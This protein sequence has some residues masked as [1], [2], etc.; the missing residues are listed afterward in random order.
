MRLSHALTPRLLPAIFLPALLAAVP[1]LDRPPVDGETD[2]APA[3]HAVTSV[4]P[5]PF[6]W[7]P[8]EGVERY[9][10][11]LS[12][13]PDF[14]VAETVTVRDLDLTVHVPGAV[15]EPGPWYWRYGY[16]RNGA[17]HFGK[18][19]PFRIA[20]DAV[21]LPFPQVSA[22]LARIPGARPRLHFTPEVL[23][24]IRAN[25]RGRHRRTVRDAVRAAEAAIARNEP[26]FEEPRS[27]DDFPDLRSQ[28][29]E[30]FIAMRPY[31]EG[32][33]QCALAY[34]L[35]GE[36]RFAEEARRRLMHFMTWDVDGTSSVIW[37][38]ELGMDIAERAPRTFDWIYDILTE[39]E[40]RLCIDVL[41]RRMAQIHA[42]HRE[43][44]FESRPYSSHPGRMIGFIIEG[45]LA[46]AHEVPEAADWLAYTL[47]LL[48]SVYP[49]WGGEEGGWHEGIGYWNGYMGRITNVLI[50]LDRLGIPIKEKPFFRNTGWFGFYVAYPGR[51]Q[52]GF[53]D[54]YERRVTGGFGNNLY[55]FSTLY[56]NPYFR[57]SAN[58]IGG[59]A[60]GPVAATILDDTL[61]EKSPADLPHSRYFP[62]VGWVAMHSDLANPDDNVMVLFKSAV[63]GSI[64]HD[65]A[66]QNAFTIDAFGE[67]LAISSGF[68]QLYGTG[69]HS[70]WIWQTKAHNAVLVNGE[71][72]TPRSR[73]ARGR[74][75]A[76]QEHG[77][78]AYTAGDAT[79]AYSGR[80]GRFVRHVIFLRPAT[81][82]MID[83]LEGP[84]APATFQWLL[85]ARSE[86]QL[87]EPAATATVH[88][89]GAR[90]RVRFLQPADLAFSQTS[91]WDP[92]LPHP[93]RAPPQFHFTASTRT[94]QAATRFV[95]VLQPQRATDA[96]PPPE[97]RMIQAE[98]GLAIAIGSD[99]VLWRAPEA[100][101][102]RAAGQS[103]RK[104]A[105]VLRGAAGLP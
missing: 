54:G 68:Y 104:P 40:R 97:P 100:T 8:L 67:P 43:L 62:D 80:L 5:P 29:R 89:G 19:R 69:H 77:D 52:L 48:W 26:L 30:I 95:T 2:Y 46:L 65:H 7:L 4:N 10:L 44:P 88:Q 90:M 12:R 96:V 13:S 39:E 18:A 61:Q 93:D 37:P 1:V 102:V 105:S 81:I 74:I 41:G 34:V 31:T 32:M 101:E 66:N 56:Q 70:E 82:L 87:D 42:L 36:R 83:D 16:T 78:W 14:T 9:V 50:E 45:S 49:A 25:P 73:A 85:H 3:D 6:V 21:A 23:A 55:R 35:T 72:Q 57:W 86:L 64:S 92:P 76:Y 51:Q 47:R 79:A 98:G 103:S 38:S 17:D 94:A 91:G 60:S 15:M 28:Y 24:E 84:G 63:R 11:Q 27:W 53:G 71:G 58:R 99:L 59:G 22:L 33:H 20:G 75:T